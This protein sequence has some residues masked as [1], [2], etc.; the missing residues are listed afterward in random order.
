MLFKFERITKGLERAYAYGDTEE[1]AIEQVRFFT[2]SEIDY[3]EDYEWTEWTCTE[4][5]EEE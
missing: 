2:S 5:F 4:T 3:H 1:E